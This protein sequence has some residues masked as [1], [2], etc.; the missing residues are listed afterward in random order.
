[1]GRMIRRPKFCKPAA[2]LQGSLA[3]LAPEAVEAELNQA[4]DKLQEEAGKLAGVSSA[5]QELASKLVEGKPARCADYA[6]QA[7]GSR[8]RRPATLQKEIAARKPRLKRCGLCS[9]SWQPQE[10]T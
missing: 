2:K 6:S 10:K 8:P 1:M 9:N 4:L 7:G 3:T 5:L